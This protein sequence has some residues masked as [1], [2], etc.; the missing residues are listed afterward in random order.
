MTLNA[1]F[2]QD[3]F[4]CPTAMQSL[5]ELVRWLS[6]R[7]SWEE[8]IKLASC[9]SVARDWGV[10]PH[11]DQVYVQIVTGLNGQDLLNQFPGLSMLPVMPGD[12]VPATSTIP[13]KG[14]AF[15]FGPFSNK[16]DNL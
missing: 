8:S 14:H 3:G 13:C 7:Q 5:Q 9:D 2:H 10:F 11:E 6:L 4:E 16:Y 1:T 15:Y 12:N